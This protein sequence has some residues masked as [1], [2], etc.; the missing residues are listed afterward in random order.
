MRRHTERL[1]ALA[2]LVDTLGPEATLRRGFSIT[3]IDGRAIA[4]ADQ[5]G[6]G[7]EITTT[8]ASGTITS[9]VK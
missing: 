4:S 5:A 6:S 7:V 8:L 2:A 3:R 9:I 1:K